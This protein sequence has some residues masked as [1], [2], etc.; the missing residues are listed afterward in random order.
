MNVTGTLE[1]YLLK[2][3]EAM[4]KYRRSQTLYKDISTFITAAL[5]L[6]LGISASEPSPDLSANLGLQMN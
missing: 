4:V 6:N 3:D 5:I 1:V 2:E